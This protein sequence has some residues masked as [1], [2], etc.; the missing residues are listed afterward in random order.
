M[1][2]FLGISMTEPQH[3]SKI[4]LLEAATNVVRIKGYN[5]ARVDDICAAAGVTKG[6]F[7]H[8]FS[9]KEDLVLAAVADWDLATQSRFAA[10]PYH[11]HSDPLDRLLGYIEFRKAMFRGELFDFSC[12]VAALVQDV[13]ENHPAILD[14]CRACIFG[15]VYT[16]VEADIEAAMRRHAHVEGFTAASLA[17]HIQAVIQGA[18]VLAKADH[19]GEI[20]STCVDQLRLHV[21][22][23]FRRAEPS[24]AGRA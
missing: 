7:F 21:E 9:T 2:N 16:A 19:S 23:L 1:A 12:M 13:Y 15:Q 10:A 22:L 6:S 3:L 4:K 20:A 8:H 5:A 11:G 17:A 24:D 14:A 18:L